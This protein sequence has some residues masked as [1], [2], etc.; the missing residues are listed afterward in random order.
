MF[1]FTFQ[2]KNNL[3]LCPPVTTLVVCSSHLL[4][5]IANNMDPDQTAPYNMDPDQTAL[6]GAA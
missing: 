3:T 6:K 2:M 4:S 1:G 5:Y